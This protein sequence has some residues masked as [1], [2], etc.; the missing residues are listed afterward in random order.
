ML[1]TLILGLV[2]GV[3]GLWVWLDPIRR[4][5]SSSGVPFLRVGTIDSLPADG[6]PR[7]FSVLADQTDAWTRTPRTSIGAVYLRRTA[8]GSPNGQ[9]SA[10]N[11]VC[12][13][14]G[15]FVDYQN[16]RQG[17]LCPCH[18]SMFALNGRVNAPSSPSPRGLDELP[19]E[20][21]GRE[22]WVQFQNF[23]TGRHDKVPLS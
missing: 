10:L 2:P 11:V 23:H 15:C 12:P 21:R 7:R 20:V 6:V 16:S 8:D 22:I 13:H 18:N 3:A 5:K 4:R 17:Y 1:V 9:L 19:V 14:A